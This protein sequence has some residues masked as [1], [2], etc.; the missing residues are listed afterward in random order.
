MAMLVFLGPGNRGGMPD[1][2]FLIADSNGWAQ[3]PNRA[4]VR[5]LHD[6]G[7][8]LIPEV[9]PVVTTAGRPTLNLLPGMTIFDS[10]LGKPIWR[11]AANTGWVDATGTAA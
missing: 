1:G 6:A 5:S 2:T 11:N 3:A 7:A 10:T 8:C 9:H 4:S